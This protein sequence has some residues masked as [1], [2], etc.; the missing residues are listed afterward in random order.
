MQTTYGKQVRSPNK[1]RLSV[2]LAMIFY[3]M[4]I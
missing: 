3:E 2:I 4:V 1:A